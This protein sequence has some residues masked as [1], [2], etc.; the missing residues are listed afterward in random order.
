MNNLFWTKRLHMGIFDFSPERSIPKRTRDHRAILTVVPLSVIVNGLCNAM[1]IWF[2]KTLFI[3]LRKNF[4]SITK[5][6]KRVVNL[7][8]AIHT[9][10][11]LKD[12]N[13]NEKNL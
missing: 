11:N 8:K 7:R 12:L 1:V 4:P 6:H 13:L 9:S 2:R 5:A 3:S 10:E